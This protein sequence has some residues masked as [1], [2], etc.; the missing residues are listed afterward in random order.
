MSSVHLGGMRPLIAVA[1]LVMALWGSV[2][3][4]CLC[5]VACGLF[6]LRALWVGRTRRSAHSGVAQ[7][8]PTGGRQA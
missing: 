4:L 6:G 3:V 5:V 1:V 7:P 8:T 2:G